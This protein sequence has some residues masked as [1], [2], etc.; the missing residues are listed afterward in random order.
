[1]LELVPR[2]GRSGPS[3]LLD[4]ESAARVVGVSKRQFELWRRNGG[5][6]PWLALGRKVIRYRLLDI[7]A[8]LR[9]RRRGGTAA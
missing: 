5:G 2:P 6:P 9:S 4:T 8:W 3:S 7:E 1:M